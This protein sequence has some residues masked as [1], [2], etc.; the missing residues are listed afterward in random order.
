MNRTV[1]YTAIFGGYD[2]LKPPEPQDQPCDFVCFTDDQ[3]PARVGEWHVVHVPR[4]SQLHSRM[5][6]KRFKLLS[7]RMCPDRHLADVYAPRFRWV[8]R[9]ICQSGSTRASKSTVRPS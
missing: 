8:D 3:M 5:R 4:D 6:A 9:P 1:V 2:T 7:R